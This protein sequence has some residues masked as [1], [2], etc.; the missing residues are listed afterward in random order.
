[1]FGPKKPVWTSALRAFSNI[2]CLAKP[3]HG[4]MLSPI[5]TVVLSSDFT[6]CLIARPCSCAESTSAPGRNTPIRSGPAQSTVA[7]AGQHPPLNSRTF[8]AL[9]AASLDPCC[10]CQT[11]QSSNLTIRKA[12]S[13]SSLKK[14]DSLFSI[15]D[16]R[17][18]TN[19]RS[20]SE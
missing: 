12:A 15:A 9:R 10:R 7:S 1:M 2:S 11:F 17:L 19:P 14:D 3:G 6:C 16:S 20:R 8:L 13:S 18:G 5:C 4:C